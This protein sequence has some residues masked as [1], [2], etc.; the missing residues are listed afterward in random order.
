M[1]YDR[2]VKEVN[3]FLLEIYDRIKP[4]RKKHGEARRQ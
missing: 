3:E 4:I 2:D 1:L